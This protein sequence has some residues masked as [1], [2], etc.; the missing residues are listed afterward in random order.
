MGHKPSAPKYDTNAALAEQNRLNQAA[1]YQTYANVNSPMGSYSVSVDPETGKMTVNKNLSGNSLM[2][3]QIQ[4]N[5]LSR[6][7]ADPQEATRAYYDSQMAY[8]QPTFDAQIDAAKESMVNRGI[9]MGSKTWNDTLASIESAQDKAKTAIANEAMLNA[10]NY[11]NNIL[12]QAQT[13]GDLVIDPSLV[14]GAKGA[15]LYNTYDKK[16]QNE[17]DI[18]KSKMARYNAIN[19]AIW[20]GGASVAGNVI[21]G[22]LGNNSNNN[23]VD[24][25]GNVIGQKGGYGTYFGGTN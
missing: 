16:F 6:F 17:Q 5:A 23:I 11:Q 19:S 18:Y 22:W 8:V 24:S 13:A 14:E 7:V 9:A 4:A 21:G 12:G 25:N 15:G 3:Q 2:A 20:S 10:Q 1:G